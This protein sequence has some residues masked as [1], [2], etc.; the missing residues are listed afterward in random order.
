MKRDKEVFEQI[1]VSLAGHFESVYYVD[2]ESGEYIECSSKKSYKKLRINEHGEDFFGDS[3]RSIRLFVHPDDM[4]RVIQAHD[5]DTLSRYLIRHGHFSMVYRLIVDGRLMRVRYIVLMVSDQ[6]HA[7]CCLENIEE[8]IQK[9]EENIQKLQAARR[10]AKRDELTGVR[11]KNAY[12]EYVDSVD[13]NI[14]GGLED[15][16]FG[17]VVCDV[18]DLKIINDTRGHSF[19]D[20]AIQR[21]CRM[22]CE[23]FSH[24]PVFRVGGDEFVVV[25]SGRDYE[26]RETLVGKL[27]GISIA[28]GRDRS[29][30]VVACGLALYDR[31]IDTGFS[32]VFSRADHQMYEDKTKLKTMK[33]RDGFKK[34]GREN[35]PITDERR[36]LLD[37]MFGAMYTVAGG[38]YVYLNDMRYDFS[39]WSL[40]LVDDFAMPSE[41]MYRAGDIWE[42]R[43]HPE[44]IEA[45]RDAVDAVF[46]EENDPNFK[47]LTYRALREDGTYAVCTT[48]GFVLSDSEGEPEYFGGIIITV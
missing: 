17:I 38:G 11:N 10:M 48:R 26:E 6:K 15:Y 45:Y 25:L 9:E 47:Q 46:N 12:R 30:P 34:M 20:E 29:G 44:D 16:S 31:N 14:Q 21:A 1:A 27:K 41:Y 43:V 40:P 13:N 22:I 33:L 18:N 8:E 39:R 19:G 42:E 4:E 37:G 23:T 32:D 2:L 5:K 35:N 28:N 24:S 7:I 36:R 3:Q